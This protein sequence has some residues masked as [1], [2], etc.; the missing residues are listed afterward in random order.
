MRNIFRVIFSVLVL[1]CFTHPVMADEGNQELVVLLHGIG[2]AQWNMAGVEFAFQKA[3]YQTLS[4]TH[5]FISWKPSAHKQI[6]YFLK[7]GKFKHES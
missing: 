7:H 5:S 2:H 6:I 4:A 3:G 1:S